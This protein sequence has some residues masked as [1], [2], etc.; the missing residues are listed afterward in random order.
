MSY[1][2]SI[3]DEV[4]R[5]LTDNFPLSAN[6]F[7]LAGTDSL[8]ETGVIDSVGV[9]ELIQFVESRYEIE[10]PDS[11]VLPENLDSIDAITRYVSS[12]RD[13]DGSPARAGS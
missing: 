5:F 13:A 10:I 6:G 4:R 8:L 11:E 7:S 3:E 12:K 1:E 9:L 2:R